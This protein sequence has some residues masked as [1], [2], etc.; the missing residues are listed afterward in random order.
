MK[1]TFIIL[2]KTLTIL[3]GLFLPVLAFEV[4]TPELSSNQIVYDSLFFLM[5]D[6]YKNAFVFWMSFLYFCGSLFYIITSFSS[7]K[8]LIILNG[9]SLFGISVGGCYFLFTHIGL[10]TIYSLVYLLN[11]ILYFF[12]IKPALALRKSVVFHKKVPKDK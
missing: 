5:I 12:N 11:I 2:I 3:A 7:N 9:L 1:R 6:N 8:F 4:K 10:G